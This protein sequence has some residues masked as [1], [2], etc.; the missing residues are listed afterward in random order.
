MQLWCTS[1]LSAITSLLSLRK[2]VNF[3]KKM[4]TQEILN[5][6]VKLSKL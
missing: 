1:L 3:E 5:E 2:A 4:Q 6:I